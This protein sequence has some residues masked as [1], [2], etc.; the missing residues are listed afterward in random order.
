MILGWWCDAGDPGVE[1]GIDGALEGHGEHLAIGAT[2][3]PE[4]VEGW[5]EVWI[6]DERASGVG[7]S[8]GPRADEGEGTCEGQYRGHGTGQALSWMRK[9]RREIPV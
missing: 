9:Q 4:G 6:G 3:D 7:P 5:G 1:E 2:V 8:D